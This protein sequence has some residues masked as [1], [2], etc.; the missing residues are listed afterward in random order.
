MSTTLSTISRQLAPSILTEYHC[1]SVQPSS[2][3]PSILGIVTSAGGGLPWGSFQT[4]SLPSCTIVGQDAVRARSGTRRAWGIALHLPSPPQRQSWNRHALPLLLPG[5][6]ERPPPM[7]R[8]CP[9]GRVTLP[10]Q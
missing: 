10:S 8:Q 6:W 5:P 3:A 7:Y 1:Q 4:K 9:S 2:S